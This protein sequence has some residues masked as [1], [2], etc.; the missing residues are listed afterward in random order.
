V[1]VHAQAGSRWAFI[2]WQR[3]GLLLASVPGHAWRLYRIDGAVTPESRF[4]GGEGIPSIGL[5]GRP[6]PFG[7]GLPPASLDL[8]SAAGADPAEVLTRVFH[9]DSDV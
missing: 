7:K 9:A 4:A 3:P 8:L 6:V 2:A 5:I 1:L